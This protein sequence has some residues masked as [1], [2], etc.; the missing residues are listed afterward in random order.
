MSDAFE[1]WTLG[2]APDATPA[3]VLTEAGRM[4]EA[5]AQADRPTLIALD[6]GF[7]LGWHALAG[8]FRVAA[9]AP[10]APEDV[11]AWLAWLDDAQH[12]HAGGDR[13]EAAVAALLALVRETSTRL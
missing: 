4:L 8:R 7:Q 6:G 3:E 5:A 1:T 10:G 13:P 12:V 11:P 9:R 2:H